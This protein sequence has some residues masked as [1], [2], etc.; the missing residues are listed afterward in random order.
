[1]NCPTVQERLLAMPSVDGLADELHAHLRDCSHCQV[2]SNRLSIIHETLPNLPVPPIDRNVLM[3]FLRTIQTVEVVTPVE[4]QPRS[5][6]AVPMRVWG[7]L[8][9]SIVVVGAL[10]FGTPEADRPNPAQSTYQEHAL[11]T[12][13][14]QHI[15]A[16]TKAD[17]APERLRI[18]TDLAND[19]G[20]ETGHIYKIADADKMDS[21]ARMYDKTVREGMVGQ[22]KQFSSLMLPGERAARLREAEESLARM[23]RDAALMLDQAPIQAQPALQRMIDSAR[24]GQTQLRGGR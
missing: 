3:T 5:I 9:A 13:E 22:A 17:T 15:A 18:L 19:Y 7:A 6:R 11:L 10:W 1:M 24:D 12:R 21:L 4:R 23:E 2:Y 14:V 20:N 8:A 16:L